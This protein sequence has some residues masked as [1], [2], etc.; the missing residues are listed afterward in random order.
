MRL[1]EV[2]C[3]FTMGGSERLAVLLADRL[4]EQGMHTSVCTTWG[5]AGPIC[6]VMDE[7]G[8]PWFAP[9]ESAGNP[10][11]RRLLLARLFRSERIDVLH[12]HHVSNLAL[13]YWPA[14]L[15]GVR[16]IVV[17]EHTD[18]ELR[19]KPRVW[20]R[21]ARFGPKAEAITVIHGG[22]EQLFR[23]VG[24]PGDRLHRI[25]NGV[26]TRAFRPR[27]QSRK[28]RPLVVGWVGRLHP[29]KDVETWLRAAAHV[30]RHSPRPVRF[31]VVGD[32]EE[33]AHAQALARTLGIA[34]RVDFH[35][36]QKDVAAFLRAMDVLALSSRTEGVPL[37]LLEAMASG[38]PC[39]ATAVG[40]IPE[41]IQPAWGR[42]APPGEPQAL[43]E[44]VLALLAADT[45]RLAM[46]KAAR[47][48]AV[49]RFG[50]ERMLEHYVQV[51]APHGYG[52]RGN[53]ASSHLNS[54]RRESEH[55]SR[56]TRRKS[57]REIQG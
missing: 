7:K 44:A 30:A 36:A 19:H 29:D 32:G 31:S 3:T 8:I 51:L 49:E 24:I 55:D 53:D 50:L 15:A 52:V 54:P 40:G 27:R 20:R 5:G 6:D 12:L 57:N 11:S 38:V 43:A 41:L 56:K 45:E 13:C 22:L 9:V 21:T 16:R 10:L 37:V 2:V 34:E 35:G 4:R 18:F 33:S 48:A 14:R 47:T 23:Q 26:D 28:P 25:D 42:L 17:T 1:M 39:V 46:G